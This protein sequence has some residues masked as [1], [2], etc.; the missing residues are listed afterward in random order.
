MAT[1]TAAASALIP[2]TRHRVY[3]PGSIE[4]KIA[5]LREL[6]LAA[7]SDQV[8]EY[9]FRLE[10]SWIHHD[11]A[12]EGV[13]YDPHELSAAIHQSVVSDSALL[14]AYDEIRRYREAIELIRQMATKR[15]T[16]ITLDTM[17]QI[18]AVLAPEECEGKQPP[19]YRKDMPLHRIYFHEIEQPEKIGYRMRQLVRW[20]G[21]DEV[22]RTMHPIRVAA[23][24]HHKL[25]HIFPFP[26]HSGRLA[27]LL[28]NMMLM[29]DGYPPAIVHATERQRYY[30]ALKT[31]P[32]AVATVIHD[33][34][35]NSV[36]SGMRYFGRAS[37]PPES[38]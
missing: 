18:Y 36:D 24:A 32:D 20:L 2:R 19:R 3:R 6:E 8:D 34:L 27:R 22:K 10:M 13:V 23:K 29:R 21:S 37:E 25:L 4:Q 30:E 1:S 38:A 12:L 31:S 16:S 17:K 5:Q 28:M 9:N 15:R 35:R 33:A 11:N 7:P 26:Q 14:P